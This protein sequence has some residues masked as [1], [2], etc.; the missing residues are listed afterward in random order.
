MT[1]LL[2]I[3]H[4][5]STLPLFFGSFIFFYWFYKRT[6]YAEDVKIELLAFFTLL[7]F[8]LFAFT[9][10]ILCIFFVLKNRTDWK[11]TIIPIIFI[12][13]TFPVIDFYETLHTSLSEKAF[14]RIKNKTDNQINRI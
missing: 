14:V 1:R 7:G 10:L 11:K 3:I 9:T 2:K 6:W 12:I 5:L 8:L 4:I 13:T